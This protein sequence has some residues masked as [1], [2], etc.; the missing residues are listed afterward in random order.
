MKPLDLN[1]L[2]LLVALE[3]TRHLGRAA[4]SLAMSQSGFSTAF[5]RLRQQVGDE[6]FVRS[7]GGMRPTPRGLALAETARAAVNQIEHDVLGTAVFD[8]LRTEANFRLSMSD[9]AEVVFV[10]TLMKHLAE[11]APGSSLHIASPA[12][13]P[14]H[15][16]LSL[17]EI[18]LAIGY[19][20]GMEKDAY[21]RQALYAH[22]YACIVRRGH[23]AVRKGMTRAVYQSLGHAVVATPAKSNVLLE[24]ALERLGLRRRIVL[25]S[26]NHLSLPATIAKSDLVATV[27]LGSAIDFARSGEIDVLALPFRPPAFTI[28]QYWHRRT[29][30]EPSCQWLRGQMKFLFN[31]QSDPYAEQRQ[32][33]YGS[34]GALPRGG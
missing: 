2:R 7:G 27:P 16:R 33:L 24:T 29:Q 25:S 28:Y 11:H 12:T 23:P 8:P 6:L 22:T 26:P 14:L 4:E 9:V 1:L 32:R 13:A 5:S 17:G 20:P 31:A 19:F 10:P 3:N 30:K 18:D 15:E 21:Y 34:R